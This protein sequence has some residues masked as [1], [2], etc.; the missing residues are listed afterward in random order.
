MAG[1]GTCC[2]STVCPYFV[3]SCV[4]WALNLMPRQTWNKL[5]LGQ[6]LSIRERAL[7]KKVRQRCCC[8]I[9]RPDAKVS[10]NVT[11]VGMSLVPLLLQYCCC[12]CSSSG[13]SFLYAILFIFLSVFCAC[14][15]GVMSR[16]KRRRFHEQHQRRKRA[17][18]ATA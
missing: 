16:R 6:G 12:F 5:K 1:A 17:P 8:L 13:D 3:H 10:A 11:V 7:K 4:L 2:G 15:D 9:L 18:H 14:C